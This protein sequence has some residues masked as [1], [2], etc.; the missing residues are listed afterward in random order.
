MWSRCHLSTPD[1]TTGQKTSLGG[2][3]HRRPKETQNT[4]N[5]IKVGNPAKENTKNTARLTSKKDCLEPKV[6]TGQY[7]NIVEFDTW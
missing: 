5:Q 1:V 4:K 3:Q 7:S 2:S 6:K